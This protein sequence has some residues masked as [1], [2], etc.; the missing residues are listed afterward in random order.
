M[1]RRPPSSTPLY[2]SAASDVYKRQAMHPIPDER[3][4][5]FATH[6]VLN[7]Q[8]MNGAQALFKAFVEAGLDTCFANPGTSEVQFV[9]E[10]GR[11]NNV[12]AVLC[13]QENT[14]TG[15]ADG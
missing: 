1:I 13:L 10:M 12:R 6:E 14:V 3:A 11:A 2:S 9:F 8:I 15:A 5:G 4:S 7:N